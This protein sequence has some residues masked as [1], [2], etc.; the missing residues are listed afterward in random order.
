MGKMSAGG[1]VSGLEWS[2]KEAIQHVLDAS[3]RPPAAKASH[4][5]D[6]LP[7]LDTPA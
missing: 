6:R 3:L 4:L 5:Q 1:S 2:H 7:K